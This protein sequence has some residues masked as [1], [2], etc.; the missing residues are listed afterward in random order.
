MT[1]KFSHIILGFFFSIITTA[2]IGQINM[3]EEQDLKFQ[4]S[5][6]MKYQLQTVLSL[7]RLS[8]GSRLIANVRKLMKQLLTI[9]VRSI[10][11]KS[12]CQFNK[13]QVWTCTCKR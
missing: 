6:K 3:E 5:T 2:S 7:A 4:T 8:P 9:R 11:I 13:L 12:G 10:P 1:I